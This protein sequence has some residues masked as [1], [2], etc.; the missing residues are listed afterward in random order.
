MLFNDLGIYHQAVHH[1]QVQ[2]QDAVHC[3]KAFRHRQSLVGGVV[4]GSLKPL[5]GRHQHGI[6]HIA[7]H[8]VGQGGN[9]LAAHGI[10]LIRH[11]G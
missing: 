6:H 2:V 8:I 1:V 10:P 5:G 11:G 3:Q 7:H 9:A 4:Q